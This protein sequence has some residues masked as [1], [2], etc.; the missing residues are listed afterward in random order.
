VS[1]GWERVGPEAEPFPVPEYTRRWTIPWRWVAVAIATCAL[2]GS[3]TWWARYAPLEH[4]GNSGQGFTL[5]S[6]SY[7]FAIENT[8]PFDVQVTHIELPA[9]P[10]YLWSPKVEVVEPGAYVG[11]VGEPRQPFEPFTIGSGEERAIILSGRTSCTGT[12]RGQ[13]MAI[14]AIQVE[15]TV[16]GLSKTRT[17]SLWD[18]YQVN[19]TARVCD[20]PPPGPTSVLPNSSNARQ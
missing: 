18:G 15:F 7:G 5:T 11:D 8:G 17:I 3:I 19:P 10:G 13:D 9:I 4:A 1:V 2:A 6:S 20:P 16:L 12:R 14:G